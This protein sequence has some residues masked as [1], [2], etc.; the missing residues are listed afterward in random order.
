MHTLRVEVLRRTPRDRSIVQYLAGRMHITLTSLQYLHVGS[1]E[2]LK[3]EES[4]INE[5]LERVRDPNSI[6]SEMQRQIQY[7]SAFSSIGDTLLIPGST[8]KGN[9][10]SRLEL[11]F[12]NVNGKADSCFLKAGVLKS[13]PLEGMQGWRHY[14]LWKDR[15]NEDRGPPCDYTRSESVCLIC[16]LFGTNGLRGLVEFSDLTL[17]SGGKEV[18]DLPYN[19]RLESVRPGSVFKGSINF[20]NVMPEELGLILIGMGIVE[21]RSGRPVLLGRLKY[22]K[23]T[24]GRKFGRVIYSVE[25]LELS[26]Y[27]KPLHIDGSILIEPGQNVSGERLEKIISQLT[28]YALRRYP[29]LD[30]IDEVEALERIT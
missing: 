29:G 6:K 4:K 16:D 24:G 27:S 22:R 23:E 3:I 11:S 30:V 20:F 21:K 9:V 18:L 5:I 10:R 19:M 13:E 1:G 15:I 14:R 2:E 12:K 28:G 26:R 17:E 8:V 7:L 25:S